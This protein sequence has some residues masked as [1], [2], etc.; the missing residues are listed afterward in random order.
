[1]KRLPSIW[2]SP[3]PVKP[4]GDLCRELRLWAYISHFCL[5][6]EAAPAASYRDVWSPNNTITLLKPLSP[7]GEVGL[8]EVQLA[9]GGGCVITPAGLWKR[10]LEKPNIHLVGGSCIHAAVWQEGVNMPLVCE[11]EVPL[12]LTR[13][14]CDN[15][16]LPPKLTQIIQGN[17]IIRL[18]LGFFLV[19][20]EK[21]P[22]RVP[23]VGQKPRSCLRE[24]PAL[25]QNTNIS[26]AFTSLPHIIGH[27][28]WSKL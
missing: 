5:C 12:K 8:L 21:K 11:C 17:L 24:H 26:L 3:L 19:F 7:N 23:F 15:T 22:L 18:Y 9:L 16:L 25:W 14:I 2:G 4:G 28:D 10:R 1:M 6:W 27:S 20:M 13:E